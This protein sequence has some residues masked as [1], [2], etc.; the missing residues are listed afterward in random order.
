LQGAAQGVWK[1]IMAREV[2]EREERWVWKE[3]SVVMSVNEDMV[4]VLWLRWRGRKLRER[5]LKY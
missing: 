2:G 4:A 1:E 5:R 3:V